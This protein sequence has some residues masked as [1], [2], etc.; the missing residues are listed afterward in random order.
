M[1]EHNT[2]IVILSASLGRGHIFHQYL[3]SKHHEKSVRHIDL[4]LI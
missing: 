2:N 3:V 1:T 4:E